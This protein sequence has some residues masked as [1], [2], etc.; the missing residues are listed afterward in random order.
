MAGPTLETN[1]FEEA[2]EAGFLGTLIDPTPNENYTVQGVGAGLPTPET[3]DAAKKAAEL[4]KAEV[5]QHLSDP[6]AE[7]VAA[8][9]TS[10]ASSS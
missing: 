6:H 4:R 10:K 9:K 7:A 1:S 3:D 8:P 5:Q 2:Q